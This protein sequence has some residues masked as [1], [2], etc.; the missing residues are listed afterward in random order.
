[1]ITGR[2]RLLSN[3]ELNRAKAMIRTGTSQRRAA[4]ILGVSHQTLWRRMHH[5]YKQP[6]R[7]W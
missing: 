3:A 2:P 7:R 6:E 5:A 4:M 1:M